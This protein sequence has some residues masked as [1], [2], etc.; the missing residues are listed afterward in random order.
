M[1]VYISNSNNISKLNNLEAPYFRKVCT[2]HTDS[3]ND[4]ILLENN[5]FYRMKRNNKPDVKTM[6]GIYPVTVK[7][8]DWIKGEECYQI[9]PHS[10]QEVLHLNVYKK[11]LIEWIF[12]YNENGVL[13]ENYFSLP[14]GTDM[15]KPDVKADILY[16]RG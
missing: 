3:S 5:R 6:L 2:I 1:R 7:G 13:Q 11:G 10:R 9:P 8:D 16:L 15:N 4:K 14:E 12:V